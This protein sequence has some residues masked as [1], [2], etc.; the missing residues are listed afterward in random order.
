MC[1]VALLSPSLI[2]RHAEYRASLSRYTWP[3]D[4]LFFALLPSLHTASAHESSE[5]SDHGGSEYPLKVL[6]V[7]PLAERMRKRSTLLSSYSIPSDYLPCVLY[8]YRGCGYDSINVKQNESK[9]SSSLPLYRRHQEVQPDA[10]EMID[11]S[12]N[13]LTDWDCFS[14]GDPSLYCS[15]T[16]LEVRYKAIYSN[17]FY[18]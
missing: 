10:H 7:P 17:V 5:T 6:H 3:G 18:H 2:Q 14:F 4:C 11:L 8:S 9:S 1:D 12:N 15:G 16:P 13:N